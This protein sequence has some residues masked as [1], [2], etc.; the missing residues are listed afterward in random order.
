MV[1]Y[2]KKKGEKNLGIIRI[3]IGLI[4][5]CIVLIFL[6]KSKKLRRKSALLISI[7]VVVLVSTLMS[8]IS[9]E[10]AFI[11]FPTAEKSFNYF[12]GK[13]MNV[14]LVLDGE[15]SSFVVAGD[16]GEYTIQLVPK[17]NDGWKVAR[18][19]D[20]KRVLHK[21]IEGYSVTIYKYKDSK[22]YFVN[23]ISTN[24]GNVE[25]SDNCNSKFYGLSY[26]NEILNE[27]FYSYYA[28][29]EKYDDSYSLILNDK[30]IPIC[31]T[32]E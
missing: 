32:T 13:S 15:E 1:F 29:V 25:I 6:Q 22:D 23:V 8:F 27:Q 18:G 31:E 20:S 5:G 24:G 12:H 7:L 4:I 16:N 30:E 21:V 10:N 26:E 17:T 19:I 28:S 3:I 2:N 14:Q 9:F 11:T